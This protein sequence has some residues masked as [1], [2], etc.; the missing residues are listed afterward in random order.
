MCDD[1]A[2]EQLARFLMQNKLSFQDWLEISNLDSYGS[3]IPA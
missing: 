2:R 3:S 1:K